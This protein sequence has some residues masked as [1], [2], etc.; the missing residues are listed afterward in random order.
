MDEGNYRI[1]EFSLSAYYEKL[2]PFDKICKWLSVHNP[3]KSDK[4]DRTFNGLE[5][6]EFAL[7]KSDGTFIRY[8]SFSNPS[9]LRME[10]AK[11]NPI[12]IEIGP[13][14]SHKP[15]EKEKYPNFCATAK[16]LVF[17]IDISDYNDIRTCCSENRICRDC[18]LLMACCIRVIDT[19]LREDFGFQKILWVF[20]G[21]RGVHCWV[22][23]ERARNLSDNARFALSRYFTLFEKKGLREFDQFAQPHYSVTRAYRICRDYFAKLA[24]SQG[25]L[26]RTEQI[27]K[28]LGFIPI[29]FDKLKNRL[30]KSWTC[31]NNKS[32]KDKFSELENFVKKAENFRGKTKNLKNKISA[33]V[34]A[35]VLKYTY[36]RLDIEVTRKLNHLLKSPFVVHPGTG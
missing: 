30:K 2:F 18:W 15:S 7:I 23:D 5:Q 9:E 32:S 35:M 6:R 1:D 3:T 36:P 4:T 14:Y 25:W 24:D 31:D 22:S 34:I 27:D 16:E 11:K 19:A 33:S 12:R 29:E 10:V 26:S 28:I 21:R 13:I 17:D 8:Q 20:S